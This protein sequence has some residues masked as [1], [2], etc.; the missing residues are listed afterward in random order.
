[1]DKRFFLLLFI[2]ILLNKFSIAQYNDTVIRVEKNEGWWGGPVSLGY[3]MPMGDEPVEFELYGDHSGNQ[4]SPLLISSTGRWI[5]SESPFAFRF[6]SDSLIIK[7]QTGVLLAGKKGNSLRDAYR[8][9]SQQFF[10]TTGQWPDSLLLQSPQYNLWIELM[11]NPNQGDVLNY[12]KQVVNHKLPTG[13]LMIDDNWSDYYGSFD[14]SQEKFPDPSQMIQQLHTMGFKVMLW[15]CPFI[16]P[17]SEAFREL[18]SKKMLL[19]DNEG[20]RRFT[21]KQANKPLL[22]KWWNGYSACLDLTNPEAQ[23]WLKSRLDALQH[24][25]GV[26]GFKLDAG[27]AG[28]YTDSNLVSYKQVLPNE[29]TQAWAEIGLHYPLNEFRAMWKMGGKPLVQRLSDKAHNWN[30]LRLLIPNTIT[31]QLEGYTFTCPDMIG[32][33]EFSSFLPGNKI[34]QKMIVRSAQIHALM[35]MMQ[36]SVAP[37]RILDSVHLQAVLESVMLRQRLMPLIMEVIHQSVVTGE[38]AIRNLEYNFPHQGYMK[39]VD[40]FMLGNKLMVAPLVSSTDVRTVVFPKGKWK[41]RNKII[42]GPTQRNFKV[43][44]DELLYF[45]WIP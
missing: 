6:Q 38:P 45:E 1:M 35:P 17:D 20:N 43:A 12:A 32:G 42:K 15:I 10:P 3:H 23:L 11:Y 13:V 41:C 19:L 30:D 21:W 36:F 34:D 33:G 24:K 7:S 2:I 14:F 18:S 16:S 39:V 27:D 5:W 8:Y 9:A 28:F 4:S 25:Y 40:Q 31:Q 37:W 44:L 22:I 29:H 26:D